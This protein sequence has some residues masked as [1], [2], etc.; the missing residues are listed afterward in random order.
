MCLNID[1]I[2]MIYKHTQRALKM[3]R[4]PSSLFQVALLSRAF[5]IFFSIVLLTDTI[6]LTV[7]LSGLREQ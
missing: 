2:Y 6:T 7:Y 1:W 4:A 5:F 3:S